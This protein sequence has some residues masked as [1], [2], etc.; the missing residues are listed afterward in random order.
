LTLEDVRPILVSATTIAAKGL[1][2]TPDTTFTIAANDQIIDAEPFNDI[3]LAYRNGGPIRVRDVGQSVAGPT[4]NTIGSFQNGKRGI[5]LI[6]FKQPGAN[7][8]DTVDQ[9]KELL[10]RLIRN[11]PPAMKVEVQQDRTRTIRASVRDV[12]FTLG[13]TVVLVVLVIFLF[14]RS[15]WATIIPGLTVPLALLGSA[16]AMYLLVSVSIIFP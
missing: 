4:D 16:A 12:E 11:I 3:V 2:N 5:L 8:I 13:L 1:V 15:V 6:V 7:V 9:I 10:P 14:L